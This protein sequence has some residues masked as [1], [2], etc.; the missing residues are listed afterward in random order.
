MA[1]FISSKVSIYCTH[2]ILCAYNSL[3]FICSTWDGGDLYLL[4]FLIHFV[5][6]A[7]WNVTSSPVN[8]YTHK[9]RGTLFYICLLFYLNCTKYF[10][11]FV[12]KQ[13]PHNIWHCSSKKPMRQRYSDD[14]I[15]S[16]D[17]EEFHWFE[18]FVIGLFQFQQSYPKRKRG[19]FFLFLVLSPNGI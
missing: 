3:L 12:M 7:R 4:L 9:M 16:F 14:F 5:S 2:M 11:I 18:M 10:F 15:T 1:K 8:Q 19:R 6:I 17:S 13:P